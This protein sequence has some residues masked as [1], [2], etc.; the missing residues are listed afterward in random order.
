MNIHDLNTKYVIQAQKTFVRNCGMQFRRAVHIKPDLYQID[1]KCLK[2]S[3]MIIYNQFCIIQ[4]LQMP[5]ILQTRFLVGPFFRFLQ[6]DGSNKFTKKF[7]GK[8]II[9]SIF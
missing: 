6:Q 2:D 9:R 5:R 8:V 4:N 1:L 3:L 7:G